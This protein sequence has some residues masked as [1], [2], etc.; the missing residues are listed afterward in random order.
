MNFLIL[1]I[2]F[3]SIF[4]VAFLLT[5]QYILL[6]WQNQR[7]RGENVLKELSPLPN[8]SL[9]YGQI[10][11]K[12]GQFYHRLI[13]NLT[14]RNR[15]KMLANFVFGVEKFRKIAWQKIS[16]TWQYLV[17]LT[18]PK[19]YKYK[20][21]KENF[22]DDFGDN[23]GK[24]TEDV[25][26]KKF[27]DGFDLKKSQNNVKKNR[28]SSNKNDDLL[29]DLDF[30]ETTLEQE[31]TT[32]SVD[33][34]EMELPKNKAIYSNY[35]Y[36]NQKIKTD[37]IWGNLT[38]P[39]NEI[40]SEKTETEKPKNN[41]NMATIGLANITN[42]KDE[43]ELTLFEKA[44]IK[45]IEKLRDIGLNHWDLWLELG[46]LYGKYGEKEKQKEIYTLILSKADGEEKKLATYRLI[47][48]N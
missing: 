19:N 15:P 5:L 36:S 27:D 34:K 26:E 13:V 20:E 21:I 11:D 25:F 43:G 24:N 1:G 23:F 22:R 16:Q 45:L 10:L 32:I 7:L 30:K 29:D 8:F 38:P 31:K 18:R 42:T 17:S 3:C 48:M 39:R 35:N 47:G 2:I 33:K 40:K 44:E 46:D 41:D 9:F 12:F 28:E 37:D 6:T 4:G 14:G